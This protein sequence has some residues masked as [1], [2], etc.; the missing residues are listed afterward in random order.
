MTSPRRLGPPPAAVPRTPASPTVGT[1]HRL[2]RVWAGTWGV[3]ITLLFVAVTLLTITLWLTEPAYAATTPD[4][5]LGFLAL[6][7]TIGVGLLSQLRREPPPAG[8]QQALIATIALAAA[9]LMGQRAEPLIGALAILGILAVQAGLHPARRSL[10]HGGGTPDLALVI[11]AVAAGVPAV[12]HAAGLLGLARGAGPSC[13]LG[14]C[15]EGDRP[16]ELAAA[17]LAV[18][19]VGMLAAFRTPG[20]RLALWTAGAAALTLGAAALVLPDTTTSIGPATGLA[21]VAWAVVFVWV[22]E[23]GHRHGH[24]RAARSI[25]TTGPTLTATGPPT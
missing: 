16:A 18:P 17:L 8:L 2:F 6:G 19:L 25:G 10:W 14:Q 24:R 20:W 5:D 22:G 12:A 11:L 1:T 3:V 15:A 13:F 9:G 7:A 21:A 23:R 4:A